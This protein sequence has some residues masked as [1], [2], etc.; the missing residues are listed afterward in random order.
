[1]RGD[2]NGLDHTGLVG[3]HAEDGFFSGIK[4]DWKSFRDF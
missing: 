1:M 3:L 2:G 4:C